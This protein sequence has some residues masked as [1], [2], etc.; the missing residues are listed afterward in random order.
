MLTRVIHFASL[1]VLIAWQS[2]AQQDPQFTQYMFNNLYYNPGF[3]G[4]E[5]VTKLTLIG[6]TQW[7]G[8]Q[9]TLGGGGAPTTAIASFTSPIYK[10]NSG[11][12]FHVVQDNL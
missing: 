6:R 3:A 5:G 2:I 12:G 1:F 9:P 7:T 11:I 10:V 4:V 8:Y